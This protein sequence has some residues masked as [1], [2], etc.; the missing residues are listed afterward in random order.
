MSSKPKNWSVESALQ[1]I[2]GYNLYCDSGRLANLPGRFEAL[3]AP[4]MKE[5]K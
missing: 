5:P 4:T 2:E 3:D 1:Q